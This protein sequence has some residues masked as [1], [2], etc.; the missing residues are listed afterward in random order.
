V[1]TEPQRLDGWVLTYRVEVC[2]D[3]DNNRTR[4]DYVGA[5]ARCGHCNQ[6]IRLTRSADALAR[7]ARTH[8]TDLSLDHRTETAG[9]T[10]S[11]A[12]KEVIAKT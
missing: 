5:L 10:V 11:I 8:E 12:G 2:F 7:H 3:T 1:N 9:H 4:Y 6:T